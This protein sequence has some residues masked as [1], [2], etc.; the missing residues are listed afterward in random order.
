MYSVPL[1]ERPNAMLYRLLQR[2]WVDDNIT[3][4]ERL[5]GIRQYG[6]QTCLQ[7]LQLFNSAFSESSEGDIHRLPQSQMRFSAEMQARPR[8]G[9]AQYK[10]GSPKAETPCGIGQ[11][12]RYRNGV[13]V[14]CHVFGPNISSRITDFVVY[15]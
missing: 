6:I 10:N 3:W 2:G 15:S 1:F 9:S 4:V 8:S 14:Q 13:K 12:R 7:I 11:L 5:G